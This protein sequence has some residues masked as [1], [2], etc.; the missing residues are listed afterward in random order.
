MREGEILLFLLA[1]LPLA[2]ERERESAPAR[3]GYLAPRRQTFSTLM[4]WTASVSEGCVMR[5][6]AADC[7]RRSCPLNLYNFSFG[8]STSSS[9]TSPPTISAAEIVQVTVPCR[10]GHQVTSQ[11][12]R[13]HVRGLAMAHG[14][15]CSL[16][17][18]S[19]QRVSRRWLLVES[20]AESV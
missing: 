17:V 10:P 6:V 14:Q 5:D 7:G 3:G 19:T 18:A 2:S 9:C 13:R 15:Q 4:G 12:G 16:A 8:A 11:Y 20:G 1:V